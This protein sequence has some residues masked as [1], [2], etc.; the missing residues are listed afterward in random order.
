MSNLELPFV[1]SATQDP[2]SFRSRRL[3]AGELFDTGNGPAKVAHALGVSV[4]TAVRWRDEWSRGGMKAL[5]RSGSV[6][7]PA[8]LS[9]R[10]MK[11]L[12]TIL[13]AEPPTFKNLRRNRPGWTPKVLQ[14]FIL[15]QY[16]I[17]YHLSHCWRLLRQISESIGK[18]YPPPQ[19][20]SSVPI[21][22]PIELN[23]EAF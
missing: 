7:R 12:K 9:N 14:E 2:E 4:Q 19:P 23:E 22:P 13:S 3:K 5:A 10:R 20:Q 17:Q 6:G 8:H 16:G 18:I 11:E 15:R 21:S 1:E